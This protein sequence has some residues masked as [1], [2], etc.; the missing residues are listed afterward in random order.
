MKK[1]TLFKI[2]AMLLALVLLTGCAAPA[3]QNTDAAADAPAADQTAAAPTEIK[4]TFNMQ[5]NSIAYVDPFQTDNA[6]HAI[7]YLMTHDRLIEKDLEKGSGYLPGLAESWEWTSDNTMEFKLRQGVKFHNGEDLKADD[8]VYSLERA[9]TGNS[10][11]KLSSILG[12][13]VV[14]DYTVKMTLDGFNADIEA[15]LTETFCSICNR[16]ACE[17]DEING[18]SVGTGPYMVVEFVPADHVNLTRFDGF[19]GEPVP[20]KNIN[21]RNISEDSTAL[22]ALQNGEMDFVETPIESKPFVDDDE[23]IEFFAF[24]CSTVVYLAFN[25][26]KGITADRNLRLAFAHALRYEEL[27]AY[28]YQELAQT[29][30]SNWGMTTFGYNDKI[31]AYEYNQELAKEYLAKAFPDGN[32]Q[33]TL[34]VS[35]WGPLAEVVQAQM[36]EIGMDIQIET[37]EGAALTAMSKYNTAEHTAMISTCGWNLYG[38][39]SRRVYYPGSNVNKAVIND[40]RISELIDLAVKEK[41]EQKRKEY[42]GEVQ[43]I[44]HDECYYLPLFCGCNTYSMAKGVTGIKYAPNGRNDFRYVTVPAK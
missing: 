39:D 6:G 10:A 30:P 13:E 35:T 19:W 40:D 12:T 33:M 7:V 34:Q 37:L 1:T 27:A 41:D 9:R 5:V 8:V 32:P 21:I 15:L 44:N 18:P 24:P 31:E 14:D 43:Q 26:S 16:K 28:T 23:N 25:T 38:D 11:S 36:K 42:Y 3:A 29:N 4:D 2:A 20:T 17:A 22:I